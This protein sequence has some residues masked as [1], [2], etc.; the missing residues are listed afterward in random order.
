[1]SSSLGEDAQLHAKAR[2]EALR[3]LSYRNRS[4]AEV[5]RKLAQRYP[6][7]VVEQVIAQLVEQRFLDD[8]AFALEW[9]RHRERR[10]P[11]GQSELR[12]ELQR[13]GVDGEV[14]REALDGI[15]ET[16][17]A[18]RAADA[19]ARRLTGT[20]S[21]IDYGR[22]RQ[23]VWAFLQRRGFEHSAIRSTVERYWSELAHPLDGGVDTES[24]DQQTYY[25]EKRS[26]NNQ[27][28]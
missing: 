12:R 1:M 22:F 15:E 11:R 8:G 7:E 2:Q 24:Q 28:D 18:Y 21:G 6:S 23:K 26:H 17:N 25:A 27:G 10:R 9:R 3:Y 13:L 16:D 20:D 5:R 19:M 14:I 4:R